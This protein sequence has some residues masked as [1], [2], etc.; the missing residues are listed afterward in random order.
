[1]FS[2]RGT[3]RRESRSAKFSQHTDSGLSRNPEIYPLTAFA[4]EHEMDRFQHDRRIEHKRKIANIVEVIFQFA[5]RILEI[6]P[7]MVADLSP[8]GDAGFHEVTKMIA[9]D[10]L[11]I[12]MH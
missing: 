2:R 11:F 12:V 1:M 8:A 5:E 6:L 4:E 3:W 10:L 9:G 7:I